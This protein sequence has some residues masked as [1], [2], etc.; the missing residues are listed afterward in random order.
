MTE[1]KKAT[2]RPRLGKEG[3]GVS[4]FTILSPEARRAVEKLAK[5]DDRTIAAYIRKIVLA[6][7]REKGFEVYQ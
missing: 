2:G 3:P 1:E 7:L 6:H 5:E 4:T